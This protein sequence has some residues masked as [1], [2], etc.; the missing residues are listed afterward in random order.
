MVSKKRIMLHIA[1][2]GLFLM[3]GNFA[4]PITPTLIVERNL[5]SSMFGVAMAGMLVTNFLFAPFWGNLCSYIPTRRIMSI[6]AFGYAVGQA[7]FGLAVNEFMIVGAR[8][9][10]GVFAAGI[11][12][13]YSNYVI[14]VTPDPIQRNQYLTTMLT[15]QTVGSAVGYF[16][17]GFL[18]VISIAAAVVPQ[19]IV[20]AASG[21]LHSVVCIDDTPYKHKPEKPLALRDANPFSAFAAA[22]EFTTPLLALIFIVV[23]VAGIGQTSYEQ[24]FN[25]VIK[26]QFNLSS[27][28]NGTFKAVIAVLTVVVNSTVCIWMQKKTDINVTFLPIFASA[29][30]LLG[31]ALLC[32]GSLLPFAAI[33]I[34]YNAVN[35]LRGPIIQSMVAG[36]ATPENSNRLIGFYQAMNSLGG[37]FGA[38]FAG[39]IY[40]AN[41]A[42][43]FM[44]AFAAFA[45]ATFFGVLYVR[46]YKKTEK[47]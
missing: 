24:C 28:Y 20:A 22:R 25:Y 11:F 17:G 21:V 35:A 10:S 6:C 3:C 45:L 34:L 8:M 43:P 23:A 7:I 12:T 46:T 26:D 18:G 5:D 37:I 44:L 47:V 14:N 16:I 29:A 42:Y 15:V 40:E 32:R 27:A 9:L 39:L 38:L 19:V 36:R 30:G 41:P 33:Y 2:V 4:H 31:A 1:V 13:A